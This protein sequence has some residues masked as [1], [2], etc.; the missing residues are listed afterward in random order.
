[1][2]TLSAA[3]KKDIRHPSLGGKYFQNFDNQVRS[4]TKM[5]VPN[6]H[7]SKSYYGCW[8]NKDIIR[9]TVTILS[10]TFD[11]FTFAMG[12]FK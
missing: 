7:I 2:V 1:M 3:S 10:F 4:S 6:K 8:V 11:L 12:L 5:S 9:I